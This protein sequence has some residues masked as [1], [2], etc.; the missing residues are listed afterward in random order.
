MGIDLRFPLIT[1]KLENDQARVLFP[2]GM[3][4]NL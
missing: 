3:A 1:S 4:L 2:L